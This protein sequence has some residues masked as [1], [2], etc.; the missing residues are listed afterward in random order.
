MNLCARIL[1]SLFL[2][3]SCFVYAQ[4]R[5]WLNKVERD[6]VLKVTSGLTNGMTEA[7]VRGFLSRRGLEP[8]LGTVNRGE[9]IIF[10]LFG[11]SWANCETL[12]VT[13][14]PKK[15]ITYEEW[16]AQHLTNSFL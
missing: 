3:V 15:D 14:K 6:K 7:G 16:K 13:A 5:G 2:A 12:I 10:Y 8:D 11:H 4:G 9:V 1:I